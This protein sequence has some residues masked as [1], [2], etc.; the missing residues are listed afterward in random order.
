MNTKPSL[1]L[2]V[3]ML[4][5]PQI[6]ETIYSPAL[7]AIAKSFSVS[8]SQAAQTISIYFFAFAIGVVTWGIL[9][10]KLGRRPTMIIGLFIYASAAVV[11]M[12]TESFAIILIARAVSAFGIAV[13]S[14]VTQTMLRDAFGGKELSKVFSLMGI[15]I[16]ISP[17]L[18]MLL[19]GK[20]SATGG[21]H[22]V[23]FALAA[24]AVILLTY[25]LAKLPE[26]Q[27]EKQ[28][29]QLFSLSLC[30]IKDKNVMLSAL[31]VALY[32][33]AL[34]SYYQLG[35]FIFV[36]LGFNSSL[37]GY[38]G[39]VLGIGTLL[40]SYL[41]KT[42]LTRKASFHTLLWV[43]VSLLTIGALGVYL[44]LDSIWFLTPMMLVVISFSIAIPNILSAAL[45]NYKQQTG[46][47]G[48]IF[49]L[50]Y[51]LMIGAGLTL[52]GVVQ[53]L[54]IVLVTCSA[55]ALVATMSWV[56]SR[57]SNSTVR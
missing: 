33:V 2:M 20:L 11:A 38:S 46:S 43:S 8:N 55:M 57:A 13:G 22:D 5:F 16:S 14:I 36:D 23:F 54:G 21:H 35:A 39:V 52:A 32:N 31:L 26:T 12:K 41:N 42:L 56:D 50:L 45:V 49:G 4:M 29:L 17:V 1:W 47:A 44:I 34:F 25:N 48:A 18:G 3:V 7:G 53:H 10:D 15:G 28:S 40:G 9:A 30:I 6:V 51:Y 37:F 19:G 24:M 27:K